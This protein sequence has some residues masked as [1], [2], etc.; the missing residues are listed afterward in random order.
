[1]TAPWESSQHVDKGRAARLVARQFP[2]LRDAPVRPIAT[3]W[4]N[5]VLLVGDVLFRFPRREVAVALQRRE[6]AVLPRVAPHVPLAVPVPTHVAEPDLDYPWPFWGAPMIPG[7]EL[8][9]V[10]APREPTAQAAGAFLR[11]LHDL[12]IDVD[13]PV[14]PMGRAA[15]AQRA[16]VS[17][18]W[19][20]SLQARGLWQP[21][22]ASDELL[23]S[24]IGAPVGSTVLAHGDLHPRHLLVDRAGRSTG[25]ID[26]GDTC[27]AHPSVDLS[28]AWS[29]FEGRAR[30]ALLDAYGVIDADTELRARALAL[31]LSAALAEW[32]AATGEKGLLLEYLLGLHRAIS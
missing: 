16:G 12:S 4:D 14:D 15:P 9:L 5:S 1:M 7:D 26:W 32:A 30:A 31:C 10:D 6:L 13:L 29:A 19:L 8:A 11:S 18:K 17:R 21:S 23:D 25:V 2:A 28:L 24:P 22:R 3:G 27:F 20:S